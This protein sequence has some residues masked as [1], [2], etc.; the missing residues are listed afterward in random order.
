MLFISHD[1]SVVRVLADRVAVM[2]A[3]RI[4]ETAT[5]SALFANP[6][7]PYTQEL[8]AAIPVPDPAKAMRTAR[9]R[10]GDTDLAAGA[11][12][13]GCPYAGRCPHT[14]DRCRAEMP[15]FV[16]LCACARRNHASS[17]GM[18]VDGAKTSVRC[19]RSSCFATLK[20]EN[21][22]RTPGYAMKRITLARFAVCATLPLLALAGCGHKEGR[23]GRVT[24]IVYSQDH[25]TEPPLT[26]GKVRRIA[27]VRPARR[28]EDVQPNCVVT[29]LLLQACWLHCMTAWKR[30]TPTL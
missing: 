14:M 17:G 22:T 4:L 15:P 26:P 21:S 13:D 1:L 7:Q 24:K 29:M 10:A 2:Y 3:G 12:S 28:P 27:D 18:L 9:V 6:L 16:R 8:L 5:S 30:S 11:G 19:R 20:I 25:N 23:G